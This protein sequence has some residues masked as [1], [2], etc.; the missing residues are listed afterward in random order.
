[1]AFPSLSQSTTTVWHTDKHVKKL[2]TA[3]E[4]FV[5]PFKRTYSHNFLIADSQRPS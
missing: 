4:S 3:Q 2:N 1:M 5:D